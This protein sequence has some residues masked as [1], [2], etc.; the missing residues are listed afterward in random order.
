MKEFLRDILQKSFS[1][2][3]KLPHKQISLRYFQRNNKA[4]KGYKPTSNGDQP[5]INKEAAL[6]RGNAK[7]QTNTIPPQGGEVLKY[8]SNTREKIQKF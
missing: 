5:A 2:I 3:V 8:K 1:N 7:L 4:Q 6:G